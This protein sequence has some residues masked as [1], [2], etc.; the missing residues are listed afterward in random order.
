MTSPA[1][2]PQGSPGRRRALARLAAVQALFQVEQG[3]HTVE[4]VI[5]QFLATRAQ[6][7]DEAAMPV[8]AD[9]AFFAE[10]VEG[11]ASHRND[12]EPLV[13]ESLGPS[14]TMA[15]IDRLVRVVLLAGVYELRHRVDVPARVVIN[16][17]VEIAHAFYGEREPGFVNS[18]LDRLA[19]RL[20]PQ[21]MPGAGERRDG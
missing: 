21:E 18:V 14:W 17:Y 11:A 20:R 5:D 2:R 1:A 19:R 12:I 15:R 16:E 13:A 3:E 7:S 9:R 6:E 8:D 10:L 4:E